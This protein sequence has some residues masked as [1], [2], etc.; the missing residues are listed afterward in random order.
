MPLNT[1]QERVIIPFIE[2]EVDC[3]Q[4]RGRGQIGDSVTLPDL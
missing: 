2:G 4:Y 3:S 1:G